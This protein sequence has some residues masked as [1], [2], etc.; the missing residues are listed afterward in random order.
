MNMK[1]ISPLIAAVLL[2]AVTMTIAGIMASWASSFVKTQIRTAQNQSEAMCF[3]AQIILSNA[4]IIDNVGYFTIENPSS[5]S[6]KDFRGYLFYDNP[7]YNEPIDTTKSYCQQDSTTLANLTLKPGDVH[8]F[9]FTFSHNYPKKIRIT[10][11]NCPSSYDEI[12]II[13]P[14]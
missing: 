3:G 13:S 1:G 11:A 14:S 8:T 10:P 7:S 9:N 2:I 12:N 6:L 5:T 4:K